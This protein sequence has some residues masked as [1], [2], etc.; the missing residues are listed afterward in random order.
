LLEPGL[1]RTVRLWD[2]EAGE[3][4]AVLKAHEGAVLSAAFSPDGK[5]VVTASWDHTVRLWDAAT[6]IEIAVLKAHEGGVRSAP[7]SPDGK[8]VAAASYDNTTRLWDVSRS[9]VVGFTAG[10]HRVSLAWRRVEF[11]TRI[12]DK[13]YV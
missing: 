4:I 11:A 3:E 2:G 1:N 9:E 13:P 8:R 6:G 10:W 7:F 12:K 5:R